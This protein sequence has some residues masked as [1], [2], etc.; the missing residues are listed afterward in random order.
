MSAHKIIIPVLVI[1]IIVLILQYNKKVVDFE[2]KSANSVVYD[3][4]AIGHD[5]HKLEDSVLNKL[6]SE[7]C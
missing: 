1:V 6:R 2:K 5:L 3:I 4:R 7:L